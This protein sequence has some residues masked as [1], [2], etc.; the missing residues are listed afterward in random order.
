[1]LAE[2]RCREG[3][4]RHTT[5]R[6]PEE[7]IVVVDG[8]VEIVATDVQE[9]RVVSTTDRRRPIVAVVAVIAERAVA[10]VACAH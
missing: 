10:D 3:L 4:A 7:A 6:E 8:R 1:M 5:H 2:W 9:V